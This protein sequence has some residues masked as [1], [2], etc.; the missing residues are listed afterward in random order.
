MQ[1]LYEYQLFHQ[2]FKPSIN[3]N[4]LSKR[5]YYLKCVLLIIYLRALFMS[6]WDADHLGRGPNKHGW[7][8]I[9]HEMANVVHRFFENYYFVCSSNW[10]FI[11]YPEGL[12][13]LLIALCL[14]PHCALGWETRTMSVFQN[15]ATDIIYLFIYFW[16]AEMRQ[17]AQ[18]ESLHS[19]RKLPNYKQL[20]EQ[21]IKIVSSLAF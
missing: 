9:W 5:S 15:S 18:R 1:Q 6:V 11:N 19:S 3:H 21:G 13:W 17:G 7:S 4:R 20:I 2:L 8:G 12:V 14:G 16:Y 10:G